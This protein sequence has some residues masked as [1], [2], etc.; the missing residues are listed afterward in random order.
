[1]SDPIKWIEIFRSGQHTSSNKITRTYPTD[2]LQQ[3]VETYNPDHF[4]A[5]LIVSS[6]AH[7]TGNY[8]DAELHKSQLAFGFPEKLKLA[9][10]RLLAGFK[11]LSP[12]VKDWINNGE[13][14]GF[15]SSFYLPNSPHNPYPG[16]L[17]LRHVAGCGV[18][19]PAVKGLTPPE[20]SEPLSAFP[21]YSEEQE[22]AVEF[23]LEVDDETL[24]QARLGAKIFSALRSLTNTTASFMG[25][26]F[27]SEL[28]LI[29]RDFYSRTRDRFIEEKG[30]EEA[31]K[32]YPAYFI[33]R[34]NTIAA[35]PQQMY[36][37]YEDLA[38]LN[39]RMDEIQQGES[40]INSYQEEPVSDA[41]NDQLR[42]ENQELR[43]RIEQLEQA[44]EIDR[45]TAFAEQLVSDRKLLRADKDKEVRF[46]L[47]LDNIA[48]ADYG[49]DGQ[50]TP[51]A[52]YMA[53]LAGS[54]ELWS[55]QRLPIGPEDAPSDFSETE[56]FALPPGY[57]VDPEARKVY[58]KAVTYQQEKNCDFAEAVAA[59]TKGVY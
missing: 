2:E 14:L 35:Q 59:V 13:I 49:E 18:D 38:M 5:P 19:L 44:R 41:E 47:S 42:T 55:N 32:L 43:G 7:Y 22:G 1:M 15:S 20:L 57:S 24:E 6:P 10:D 3:V 53:K 58:Q 54:R 29:F 36:A 23:A 31:E 40:P 45:V 4:K 52:A 26:G 27:S 12:K 34:L 11:T 51:R 37:T 16:K 28:A 46:I 8:S 50:L 17:A 9:G 33:D 30:V 21:N 48:T 56:A 25:D 39:R